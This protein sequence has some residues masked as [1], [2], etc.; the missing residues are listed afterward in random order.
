MGPY[1]LLFSFI[2]SLASFIVVSVMMRVHRDNFRIGRDPQLEF[3]SWLSPFHLMVMMLF[4]A[5]SYLAFGTYY[6]ARNW[7]WAAGTPAEVSPA[8]LAILRTVFY[9]AQLGPALVFFYFTMSVFSLW[10]AAFINRPYVTGISLAAVA[11]FVLIFLPKAWRSF[12]L[13]GKSPLVLMKWVLLVA[14]AYNALQLL[15]DLLWLNNIMIQ[16]LDHTLVGSRMIL[17]TYVIA[18]MMQFINDDYDH[19]KSALPKPAA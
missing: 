12:P 8:Q 15:L 17:A 19:F 10:N 4:L 2:F 5:M 3:F 6:I 1:C 7:L 9:F 11:P 13:L 18:L 14:F 16:A